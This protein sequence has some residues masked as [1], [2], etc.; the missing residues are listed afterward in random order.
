M[1]P[2]VLALRD[3]ARRVRLTSPYLLSVAVAVLYDWLG[4]EFDEEV[5]LEPAPC[6]GWG[7]DVDYLAHR[8]D[9]VPEEQRDPER[10][11][12]RKAERNDQPRPFYVATLDRWEPRYEPRQEFVKR[13]EGRL[14]AGIDWR[15]AR[16]VADE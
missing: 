8:W 4:E 7:E 1:L 6:G 3:R 16:V 5:G 11:F 15:A 2:S 12:M 10:E 9:F 14:A 13:M